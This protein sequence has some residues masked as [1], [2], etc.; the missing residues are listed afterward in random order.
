MFCGADLLK[1]LCAQDG[2]A[3]LKELYGVREGTLA[4]ETDRYVSLLRQHAALYAE[5][6]DVRLFSAPGRTEIIGNH[7]DHNNGCVLAAAV[8][9][10]TIAAVTPRDDGVVRLSSEGYARAIELNLSDLSPRP[11]EKGTS[12]ALIRGVAARLSQLGRPVGGFMAAVGSNV[13]TGSGLSSSAAF[14]VLLATIF[15]GL[16]G[17]GRLDPKEKARVAQYAENVFFGK[18]CGLMDQ[19]ASAVGGLVF[20]DFARSPARVEPLQFDFAAHGYYLVTVNTGGDHGDL[21]AEY[22]AIPAEM[23]QVAA[24]L[25]A[26]VLRECS[27][28]KVLQSLPALRA[29][30]SD[31]AI[32]RALHFLDENERVLAQP[33]VLARGDL[34]AFFAALIASGESSWKLLQNIYVGQDQSLALALELSRRMLSGRGAWRIHG[35]GFAGTILSFVPLGQLD[36]YLQSMNEAFGANACTVLS[37]RKQGAVELKL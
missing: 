14:E 19:T 24:L 3:A 7:T 31:R 37:V 25:G 18:P 30:T 11:E 23:K 20:I 21:T 6:N 32:L 34:P 15:D 9:L 12:A 16:Y 17:D 27:A 33:D 5:Q 26:G 10:D 22:A 36:A 29:Q 13:A 4:Y 2:A 35:G 8:N 28:Q 1:L